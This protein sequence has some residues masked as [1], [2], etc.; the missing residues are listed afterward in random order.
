MAAMPSPPRSHEPLGRDHRMHRAKGIAPM[1][2]SCESDGTAWR[3]YEA[4]TAARMR[5]ITSA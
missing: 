5:E 1:G 3:S 4:A 2:R